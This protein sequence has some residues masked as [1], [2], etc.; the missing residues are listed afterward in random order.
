MTTED[1]D[2]LQARGFTAIMYAD[3]KERWLIDLITTKA[4]QCQ[5]QLADC[6]TGGFCC[7]GRLESIAPGVTLDPE[8]EAFG[9]GGQDV[10]MAYEGGV[11]DGTRKWAGVVNIARTLGSAK[12][13]PGGGDVHLGLH[14]ASAW[15]DGHDKTFTEIAALVERHVYAVKRPLT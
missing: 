9:R 2:V 11:S 6:G 3:A 10:R 5:E 15:N 8:R 7:L 12:A 13:L 4:P 1:L 14:Y